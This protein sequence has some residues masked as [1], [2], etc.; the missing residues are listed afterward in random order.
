MQ[1]HPVAQEIGARAF[2]SVRAC[3]GVPLPALR[4]AV[5]GCDAGT[6]LA[7]I[8]NGDLH[9]DWGHA[10]LRDAQRVELFVS[11]ELATGAHDPR[12]T[13]VE[14]GP[15]YFAKD[16]ELFWKNDLY[17]IEEV[18]G[19]RIQLRQATSGKLKWIDRQSLE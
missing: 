8:A 5:D 1:P 13:A 6:T 7:L 17:A 16:E 11:R 10:L 2:R 4:D 9:I 19:G 12:A 3:P 15:I 14:G 18:G